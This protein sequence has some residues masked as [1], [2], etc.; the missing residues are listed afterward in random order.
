MR[1]PVLAL[2]AVVWWMGWLGGQMAAG[3][4]LALLAMALVLVLIPALRET[5]TPRVR[6]AKPRRN[7]WIVGAGLPVGPFFAG[8]YRRIGR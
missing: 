4:V 8:I 1:T 7:R 5:P 6:M 3:F 2:G